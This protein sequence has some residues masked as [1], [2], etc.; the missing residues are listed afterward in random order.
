MKDAP[1][2]VPP[3]RHLEPLGRSEAPLFKLMRRHFMNEEKDTSGDEEKAASGAAAGQE[4]KIDES[5]GIDVM[6]F[7][8]ICPP[9][10]GGRI[11]KVE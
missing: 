1:F 9:G 10:V 7:H 8:M 11:G 2:Q 4:K 3:R 5:D 6:L